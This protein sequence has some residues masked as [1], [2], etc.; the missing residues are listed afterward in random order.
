M[1]R[2]RKATPKKAVAIIGEGITEK[3]YIESIQG[4]TPFNMHPQCLHH[5]ASSLKDLKQHIDT[6]IEE[7]FDW[8][9]CLIDKDNKVGSPDYECLKSRYNGKTFSKQSKGIRCTVRFFE[10]HRCIEVWFLFYFVYTTRAFQSYKDV[11][12]ILHKYWPEYEKTEAFFRRCGGI[13]AALECLGGS[14]PH[15]ISRG[16]RSM[17]AVKSGERDYTYSEFAEFFD[18]IRG[19]N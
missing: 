15:A 8:V 5:K 4:M 6:A 16:E 1:R 2:L 10:T 3:Y 13:H 7:G 12:K 19:D 18:L 9:L 11:E 14:L 17:A